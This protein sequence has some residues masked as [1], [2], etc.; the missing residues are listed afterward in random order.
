[1]PATYVSS[2]PKTSVKPLAEAEWSKTEKIA[3]KITFIYF[4]LLALPLDWKYFKTVFSI[5]WL[6][7]HYGDFFNL[8][9]YA[10]AFFW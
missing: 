10:P 4:L 8:A 7:L 9:H 6:D 2:I 1:M 5:N 3:F